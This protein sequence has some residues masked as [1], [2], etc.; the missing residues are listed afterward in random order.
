MW[1]SHSVWGPFEQEGWEEKRRNEDGRVKGRPLL[2]GLDEAELEVSI[3]GPGVCLYVVIAQWCLTLRD[4]M[5][6]SPPGSSVHGILQARILEGAVIPFSRGS[7][8][9]RD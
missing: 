6:C 5:D 8:Q 4:P 3:L 1:V 9:P 7:S 2:C